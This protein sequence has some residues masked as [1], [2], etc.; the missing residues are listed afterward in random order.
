MTGMPLLVD[1]WP[2]IRDGHETFV[3][4]LV[5]V[6]ANKL[7]LV[8]G[9]GI[10]RS[11]VPVVCI[12]HDAGGQLFRYRADLVQRRVDTSVRKILFGHHIS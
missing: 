4:G 9:F 2:G 10:V 12:G 6:R 1:S 5:H 7:Q 3:R 11:H 8:A